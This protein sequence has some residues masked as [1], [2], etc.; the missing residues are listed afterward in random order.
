MEHNGRR[1][2]NYVPQ[3]NDMNRTDRLLAIIL[4]PQAKG[5]LRA[6]D[7]AVIFETSV[8]TIYRDMRALSEAGVPLVAVTG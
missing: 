7:L 3:V 6:E 5:Q 4:E 8:R 2:A 1:T